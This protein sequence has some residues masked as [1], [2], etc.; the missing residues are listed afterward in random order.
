MPRANVG[1]R[2]VAI[3]NG[4]GEKIYIY[5]HGAYAGRAWIE[6]E[7]RGAPGVMFTWAER[8]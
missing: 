4:D 3:R 1:D 6:D 7:Q 8:P 5:G 2:V